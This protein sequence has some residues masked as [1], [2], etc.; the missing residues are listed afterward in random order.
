MWVQSLDWEDPLEEE[1]ATHSGILVWKILWT[2]EPGRLSFMGS[3]RGATEHTHT[4]GPLAK[5]RKQLPS[6]GLFEKS[7]CYHNKRHV[8][9]SLHLGNSKPCARNGNE[10][11]IYIHYKL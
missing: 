4:S 8:L 7:P 2:E 6:L 3:Q 9:C 11:Q 10:E 1:M 5:C